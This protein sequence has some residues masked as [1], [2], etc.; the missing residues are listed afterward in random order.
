[1]KISLRNA[2]RSAI[3]GGF[4]I[5]SLIASPY[6]ALAGAGGL[7]EANTV[8]EGTKNAFGGATP[9]TLPEL[10]SGIINQALALIGI[11]IL[12]YFLYGGFMWMTASGS[13]EKVDKAKQVMTNAVIGLIII[14]ASYAIAAFVVTRLGAATGAIQ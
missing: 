9:K 2:V 12:F 6:L 5:G 8:L 3:T 13:T 11:V 7:N 1:M 10:V 14:L 4:V